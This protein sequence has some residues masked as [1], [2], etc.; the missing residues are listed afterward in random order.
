MRSDTIRRI[1]SWVKILLVIAASLLFAYFIRRSPEPLGERPPEISIKADTVTIRDTIYVPAPQLTNTKT[2]GFAPV[3]L[4]IWIP[5][6][7][8]KTEN[9]RPQ[10]DEL[11]TE[12]DEATETEPPDSATV[13]IPMEQRHYTGDDYDAWVSGWNPSLDSLRIYRQTQHVATT[14]E[15][16]RWKKRR[17]GLSVGVGVVASPKGGIQPGIFIGA[18]YTFLAF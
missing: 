15:V 13:S 3:T 7:E 5:P 8:G 14:T 2:L 16:I 12:I 18:S 9:R 1:G 10:S 17:W 4:P 6:T 11:A